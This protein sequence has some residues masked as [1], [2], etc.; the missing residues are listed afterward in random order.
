MHVGDTLVLF[1]ICVFGVLTL[2]LNL[3]L[4]LPDTTVAH[5]DSMGHSCIWQ[6][7]S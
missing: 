2:V 4:F 1:F 6:E 7:K 5:A 3:T